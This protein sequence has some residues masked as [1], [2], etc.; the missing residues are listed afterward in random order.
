MMGAFRLFPDIWLNVVRVESKEAEESVI[1]VGFSG[2]GVPCVR[3]PQ[4]TAQGT[5]V[6]APRLRLPLEAIPL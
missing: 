5:S 3:Y 6:W 2:D 1:P 4:G